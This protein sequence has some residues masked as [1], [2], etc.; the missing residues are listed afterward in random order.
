MPRLM[1]TLKQVQRCVTDPDRVSSA[2][3]SGFRMTGL[4]FERD[5]E[6]GVLV[7]IVRQQEAVAIVITVY[8]IEGDAR[9][10]PSRRRA[11]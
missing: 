6:R 10:K 5:F 1:V 3:L 7:T 9:V 4:R 2:H 8:W 11:R